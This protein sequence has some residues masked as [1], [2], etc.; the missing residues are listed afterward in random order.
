MFTSHIY[1]MR[2]TKG[3]IIGL[4]LILMAIDVKAL[5]SV[6]SLLNICRPLAYTNIKAAEAKLLDYKQEH[7]GFP[8]ELYIA[9][10]Y[11]MID[12]KGIQYRTEVAEAYDQ[13][14]MSLMSRGDME[15]YVLSLF[16][17]G[18]NDACVKKA[19]EALSYY[20]QSLPLNRYYFR[21]L[22]SQGRYRE[23]LD[24]YERLMHADPA[25]MEHSDTVH[26]MVAMTGMMKNMI[27]LG[28]HEEADKL[29][30]PYVERCR[31]EGKLTDDMVY[32]LVDNYIAWSEHLVD[33]A[34]KAILLKAD[35]LLAKRIPETKINDD[36][37]AYMRVALVDFR[38]DPEA[39]TG[40]AVPAILQMERVF[41]SKGMLDNKHKER[42]VMGYRYMM[43]Y[44]FLEK[45]DYKTA[46]DY[47]NK[48]LTLEPDNESALRLKGVFER[49]GIK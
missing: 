6:D 2:I 29:Y 16:Y 10:L 9:Q 4:L 3:F 32:Y 18:R 17:S 1:D 35:K 25:I 12:K 22:V 41:K 23:S 13:T 20:P 40:F 38:I 27:K 46:K 14:A 24:A 7:F 15:L 42:L 11:D 39:Q 34:R 36:L 30:A 33:S 28:K 45:E 47:T 49:A 21:S 31:K 8:A 5:S 37:F 19:Q 48:L 44:Y 43:S 26:Y